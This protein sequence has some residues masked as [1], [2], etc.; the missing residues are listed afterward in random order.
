MLGDRGLHI[1][2]LA[3]LD[4]IGIGVT[5]SWMVHATRGKIRGVNRGAGACLRLALS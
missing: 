4:P 5:P 3:E 2:V 1:R